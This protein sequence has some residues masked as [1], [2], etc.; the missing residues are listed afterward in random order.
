MDSSND[1]TQQDYDVPA[2]VLNLACFIGGIFFGVGG[3]TVLFSL[4]L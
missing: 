2:W 3:L 1:H 4:G